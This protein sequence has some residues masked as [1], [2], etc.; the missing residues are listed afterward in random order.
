[1]SEYLKTKE[2]FLAHCIM[3]GKGIPARDLQKKLF[4]SSDYGTIMY[5]RVLAKAWILYVY[6]GSPRSRK[7]LIMIM[8]E[9]MSKIDDS[10]AAYVTAIV[11]YS[12]IKWTEI[13]G[14]VD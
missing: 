10:S 6:Q 14:T 8:R 11:E 2:S 12:N 7:R 13:A 3:I 9:C 1:M 4:Y 5:K